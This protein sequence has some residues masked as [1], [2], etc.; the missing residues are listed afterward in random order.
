MVHTT[1]AAPGRSDGLDQP[2]ATAR[3]RSRALVSLLLGALGLT[4]LSFIGSACVI[5]WQRARGI[6]DA[7]DS[8]ATNAMP[9]VQNLAGVRSDL[10]LM[11][12]LLIEHAHRVAAGEDASDLVPRIRSVRAQIAEKWAREKNIPIYPGE[13]ES[14]VAIDAA[15]AAVDAAIER[16]LGAT[17]RD[18]PEAVI[19]G[20]LKP[21]VDRL[22]EALLDDVQF[23]AKHAEDLA[24][25]IAASRTRQRKVAAVLEG[26]SALFAL[27]AGIVVARVLQRYIAM[28]DARIAELDVFAAR[29]AH[30]IRS[31]LMSV[32]LAIELARSRCPG[33]EDAR[34]TLDRALRSVLRVGQIADALLVLAGASTAPAGDGRIEVRAL[35]GDQIEELLPAARAKGVALELDPFD[36]VEVA[37]TSGVLACVLSNLIG[38]AIKYIGDGSE[39]RVRV[40]AR[41][42]GA[43][44]RI[45]VVDTGPGVPP[46]LRDRI[47]DPYVRATSS[48]LPGLGLGLATVHRLI[49]EHGG[50]VGVEAGPDG[51]SRFWV[52]LPKAADS[53]GGT[54]SG[55]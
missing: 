47:F 3:S 29:V 53:P 31:P 51:G 50:N 17:K 27:I 23:N 26:A 43:K 9:S 22:A 8:I 11:E 33:D 45:E 44:V 42:K 24:A 25:E 49:Q 40:S 14:W 20:S 4:A 54:A 6:E 32:G 38:N 19:Y 30:D 46:D 48:S 52:E 18:E 35:A 37:C 36:A 13:P 39:R 15:T 1:R 55:A 34:T 16:V 21:S 5:A 2:F 28:T 12:G 41:A 7:A 10:R